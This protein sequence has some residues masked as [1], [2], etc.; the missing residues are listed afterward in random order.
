MTRDPLAQAESFAPIVGPEPRALILGSMPGQ[1]SLRAQ[2]YYAHPRNALWPILG[3]LIG[4][5]AAGLTYEARLARAVA[6]G[7]ALWD[8]AHRCHRPGSLDAAMRDVEPN[9]IPGLLGR[10]PTI[11][12][13]ACNGAKAHELLTRAFRS[14]LASDFAGVQILRLP[15]TSPAHASAP[16]EAKLAAWRDALAP[17]I[18]TPASLHRSPE[19]PDPVGNPVPRPR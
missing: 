1:A 9:D 6:A 17:C 2:R 18:R 14:P 12:R 3:E 4:F 8:V 5:D 11:Q 16:F 7:I 19:R 15:S 13:I 10:T